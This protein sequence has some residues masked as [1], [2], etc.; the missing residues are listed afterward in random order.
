MLIF[1][2]NLQALHFIVCHINTQD[3]HPVTRFNMF[4]IMFL[5]IPA[6]HREMGQNYRRGS[7]KCY[8]SIGLQ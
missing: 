2:S 6:I 4:C 8:Y 5:I 7:A 1:T 3:V